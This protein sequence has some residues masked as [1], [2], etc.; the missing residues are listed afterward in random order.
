M[1]IWMWKCGVWKNRY[2]HKNRFVYVRR[3]SIGMHE[4]CGCEVNV[5]I[6]EKYKYRKKTSQY[7]SDMWI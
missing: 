5:K 7:P 3:M 2:D 1:C 6:C 4:I